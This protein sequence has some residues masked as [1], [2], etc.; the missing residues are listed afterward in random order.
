MSI[1]QPQ[2]RPKKKPEKN[3]PIWIVFDRV[4]R[5]FPESN[6]MKLKK[7]ILLL[8]STLFLGMGT[9][10]RAAAATDYTYVFQAAS[11]YPTYLNNST[12]TIQNNAGACSVVGWNVTDWN[13]YFGFTVTLNSSLPSAPTYL[14]GSPGVLSGQG[15]VE[16]SSI[17]F[18]NNATFSGSFGLTNYF[19]GTPQ[20]YSFVAPVF[21]GTSTSFT[22][23][24]WASNDTSGFEYYS[25]PPGTWR[26]ESMTVV[27]E[28]NTFELL[29]AGAVAMRVFRHRVGKKPRSGLLST[30][31]T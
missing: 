22:D 25:D 3:L 31:H 9:A 11:G 23:T 27:P 28:A 19:N 20:G 16:F 4:S 18:A 1:D 5:V 10:G 21:Y 7:T 17:S 29:L 26:F 14:A 24:V 13:P 6:F 30:K 8:A 12:I 2:N 15:F